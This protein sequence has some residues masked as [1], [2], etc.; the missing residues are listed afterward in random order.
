L[1]FTIDPFKAYKDEEILR[2]LKLV[3]LDETIEGD[4]LKH[5]IATSGS[6]LSLGQ[7]QLLSLS[8]AILSSPRIL[9]LDEA[10][11]NIDKKTDQKIQ[12]ILKNEFENTTVITIAHRLETVMDYDKIVVLEAGKLVEIGSVQELMDKENGM[13]RG[14]VEEQRE[15]E[16]QNS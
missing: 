3:G 2:V 1:R 10:T 15:K 4:I 7:R 8:R 14:M 11:S 5:E 9:L 6:N 12:N 16:G 13:F